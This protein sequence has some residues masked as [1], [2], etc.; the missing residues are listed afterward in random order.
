MHPRSGASSLG[1]CVR[2]WLAN[3]HGE[4]LTD[5]PVIAVDPIDEVITIASPYVFLSGASYN[6]TSPPATLASRQRK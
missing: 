1:G 6:F 5:V 2:G 3:R 4:G